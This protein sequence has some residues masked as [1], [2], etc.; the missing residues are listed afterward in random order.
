MV[1][2]EI[3]YDYPPPA[4]SVICMKNAYFEGLLETCI[5]YFFNVVCYDSIVYKAR[6]QVFS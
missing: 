4:A 5:L 6:P 1:L 3:D 2:H